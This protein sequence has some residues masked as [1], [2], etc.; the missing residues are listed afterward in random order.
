[1]RAY[2]IYSVVI[3]GFAYPVVAHAFWSGSGF[4]SQM[5]VIDFAGSGAVH[6]TGGVA[7]LMAA[8]AVGPRMGR[9]HDHIT[10]IQYKVPKDFTPHSTSLQML[11][12]F[13]LWFGCKYMT[14]FECATI[15]L[16][17]VPSN[18]YYLLLNEL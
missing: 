6:M 3:V 15:V 13:A 12:T 9:F 10:G 18:S 17:P 11:G 1:M 16:A 8:L 7:A 14:D 2:L 4:L 5:D